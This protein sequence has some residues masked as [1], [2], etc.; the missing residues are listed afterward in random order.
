M[1]RSVGMLVKWLEAQDRKPM[2]SE[3]CHEI[4]EGI[5]SAYIIELVSSA[6]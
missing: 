4:Y 6:L 1:L 2:E 3:Y 5:V